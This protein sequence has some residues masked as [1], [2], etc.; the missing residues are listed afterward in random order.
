[1]F[2]DYIK[3]KVE[4][5]KGGDGCVSFRREKGVP[6]GGPDGGDGGD[7]GNIVLQVSD[8]YSSL[9]HLRHISCFKAGKGAHGKGKNLYGKRGAELI[10]KVP[11]GTL[12]YNIGNEKEL[13][14]DLIFPGDSIV[15][16]KGGRGGRGNTRF[17]SSTNRVPRVKETGNPGEKAILVLELKLI[18]DVGLIGFPNA[19]KSTLLTQISNAKPKIASYPFTT[20]TPNLGV[21]QIGVGTTI[22]IADIPGIIVNAH[23]GRGLGLEFLRHIERTNLLIFVLDITQDPITDYNILR[24]ELREYNPV[25]LKKPSIVVLNKIDLLGRQRLQELILEDAKVI[26]ISALKGN[27]IDKLILALKEKYSLK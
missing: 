4:A 17:K 20:L 19:G 26:K 23:K 8:E 6:R 21:L 14:G 16:A 9:S 10:I 7:G 15:V 12:V 1:M 18:A 11:R 25:I 3:I 2:I 13:L 5:G 22:T 27:G 24:N